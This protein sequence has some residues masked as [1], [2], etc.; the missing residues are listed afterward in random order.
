MPPVWVTGCAVVLAL[1]GLIGYLT[2]RSDGTNM[3][4]A[5]RQVADRKRAIGAGLGTSKGREWHN[6]IYC[7][8][9][10]Q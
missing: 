2:H 10:S 4:A 5:W 1:L 6:T 7:D 8:Y 3:V 9:G